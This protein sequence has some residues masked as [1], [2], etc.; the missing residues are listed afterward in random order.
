MSLEFFFEV[1][2]ELICEALGFLLV[3]FVATLASVFPGCRAKK[4]AA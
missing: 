2:I 4:T 1:V 3:E